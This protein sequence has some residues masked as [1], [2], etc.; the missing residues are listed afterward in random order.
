L[1]GGLFN[2]GIAS[3][4]DCTFDNNEARGGN[5]N[6]GSSGFTTLGS[7]L[8]G[9]IYTGAGGSAPATLTA[10]HLTL[11]HN[12][13]E[14]GMR[15]LGDHGAGLG[16]IIDGL[17]IGLVDHAA[18]EGLEVFDVLGP[19]GGRLLFVGRCSLGGRGEPPVSA[20]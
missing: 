9:A 16:L 10:S 12:R 13:A 6:T 11:G 7:G 17:G 4:T 18:G 19:T 1:G 2:I 14:G 8:G 20:G 5:G 15:L 3:V